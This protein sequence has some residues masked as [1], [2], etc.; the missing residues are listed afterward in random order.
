MRRR[1][2]IATLCGTAIYWPRKVSAQGST[3][4]PVL[5]VLMTLSQAAAFDSVQ[6]LLRGLQ[7]LG[8]SEG[9]DVEVVVR[10]ADGDHS[11]LPALAQELVG[12]Q[13]RVIVTR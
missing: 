13:P 12:L 3:K 7:E 5:G 8:Y 2:V 6:A 11:R 9:R 1:E 4:P 10:Y